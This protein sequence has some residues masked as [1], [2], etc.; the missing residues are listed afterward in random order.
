[1]HGK[2]TLH[3]RLFEKHSIFHVKWVQQGT[4]CGVLYEFYQQHLS[5]PPQA[6]ALTTDVVKP[7]K[8][9]GNNSYFVPIGKLHDISA[10]KAS[11]AAIPAGNPSVQ[12]NKCNPEE[13]L[14]I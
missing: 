6:T 9:I 2:K 8:Q 3:K 13:L 4:E 12:Y 7:V 5:Q 1:M 10:K 11:Q 14:Q